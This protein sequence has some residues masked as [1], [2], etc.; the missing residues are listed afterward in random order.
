MQG[1]FRGPYI[2]PERALEIW[3]QS[4]AL[5]GQ[6]ISVHACLDYIL[7]DN[8]HLDYCHF[9]T[10]VHPDF[11]QY[12]GGD[13]KLWYLLFTLQ[14]FYIVKVSKFL[15][16]ILFKLSAS[17]NICQQ[18]SRTILKKDFCPHKCMYEQEQVNNANSAFIFLIILFGK[19]V[20]VDDIFLKILQIIVPENFIAY[21]TNRRSRQLCCKLMFKATFCKLSILKNLFKLLFCATFGHIKL[22]ILSDNFF[23]QILHLVVMENFYFANYTSCCS[24]QL[25]CE[26]QFQAKVFASCCS[27]Q[28]LANFCSGQFFGTLHKLTFQTTCL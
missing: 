23:W 16:Q 1:L 27:W 9:L 4:Q 19:N 21:Y 26:S 10:G 5:Y 22:I 20:P 14:H 2:W 24:G 7:M 8:S 12:A 3:H 11:L 17:L 18:K 28:V 13:L 25:V 6:Q 15:L